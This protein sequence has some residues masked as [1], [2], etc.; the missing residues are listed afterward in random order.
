MDV[1]LASACRFVR[2]VSTPEV[3]ELANTY[4]LEMS[5]LEGARKIYA[6]GV[7]VKQPFQF[8]EC[9]AVSC[10]FL[11]FAVVLKLCTLFRVLEMPPRVQPVC[12]MIIFTVW[13]A[14]PLSI[15]VWILLD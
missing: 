9:V 7:S 10:F 6:Q 2:F 12:R 8:L 5:Q 15:G 3:L 11:N 1:W 4:D 13:I 14:L